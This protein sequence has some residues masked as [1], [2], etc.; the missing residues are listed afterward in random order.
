MS[1]A[2]PPSF[3]SFDGWTHIA[4]GNLETNVLAVKR[5]ME[6]DSSRPL[7]TFNDHTGCVV[8]ID[9][10]GTAAEVLAR[11]PKES[12]NDK[13]KE[14]EFAEVDEPSV[15]SRGRGR[16]KLGVIA[17]EVTLL[18]RHW[19]WLSVQPGGASVALRKLVEAAKRSTTIQEDRR[20]AQ[21]RA[22]QFISVMAGDMPGFEECTRALFA[23]DSNKL[24]QLTAE[25]PSDVRDYAL[26]L[27]SCSEA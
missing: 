10:R 2:A 27:A 17:R 15:Q 20:R 24:V 19:D 21:E 22:Y 18:P 16:P 7:L 23:G 25:W 9:I 11:L 8:E 12:S 5:A 13:V 26:R 6:S 1:T 14:S 3:T 4:N